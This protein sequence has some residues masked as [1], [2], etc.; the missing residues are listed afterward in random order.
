MKRIDLAKMY[1]PERSDK[2]AVR[3]LHDWIKNCRGLEAALQALGLPYFYTKNLTVGQ[4]RLIV[5][6]QYSVP[7]IYQRVSRTSIFE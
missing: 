4:V 2:G 3:G 6:H 5:N 1:F 7:T